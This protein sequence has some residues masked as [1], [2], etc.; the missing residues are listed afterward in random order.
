MTIND[1]TPV[2][3]VPG[4]PGIIDTAVVGADGIARSYYEGETLDQMQVRYPG[5]ALGELGPVSEASEAMFVSVPVEVDEARYME[6]L[7]VLPP[8][9]WKNQGVSESFKLSER[10]SG[11][12]T[13][14][15]CRI[16]GRYFE[17]QNSVFM[18]HED[19]VRCIAVSF[20]DTMV[21]A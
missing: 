14:I 19:I 11:N 8:M 20:P 10:T 3:Y 21:A 6:M 13:A 15:F 1:K 4:K 18:S 7:E 17:M 2:F 5:A 9:H 12:I 16:Q